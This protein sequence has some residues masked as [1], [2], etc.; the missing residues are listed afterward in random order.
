MEQGVEPNV[1]RPQTFYVVRFRFFMRVFSNVLAFTAPSLCTVPVFFFFRF[2]WLYYGQKKL[3]PPI[4]HRGWQKKSNN[5]IYFIRVPEKNVRPFFSSRHSPTKDQTL[6]LRPVRSERVVP[7][8]F[9]TVWK[10]KKIIFKWDFN[11][12]IKNVPILIN[13]I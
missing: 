12:I 8:Y 11:F 9:N 7:I 1:T 6:T 2:C 10:K 13:I 4:N 5:K 3:I